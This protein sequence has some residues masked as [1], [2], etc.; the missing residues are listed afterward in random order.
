MALKQQLIIIFKTNKIFIVS[1]SD[2]EELDYEPITITLCDKR[3][4]HKYDYTLNKFVLVRRV[5][6]Y[7]NNP[8]NAETWKYTHNFLV[9]PEWT[10][11]QLMEDI[12]SRPIPRST[13]TAQ[14][15]LTYLSCYNKRLDLHNSATLAALGIGEDATIDI[16]DPD[17]AYAPVTDPREEI[18]RQGLHITADSPPAQIF[19]R[20][21]GMI[22]SRECSRAYNDIIREKIQE[23][24]KQMHDY[25]PDDKMPG[26]NPDQLW[27]Y[28]K[29]RIARIS[30]K[31]DALVF[32]V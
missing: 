2:D 17:G 14:I 7:T 10:A 1:M 12:A 11:H 9:N 29:G 32:L 4:Y 24:D 16:M 31:S 8:H 27:E 28:N 26:R 19:P 13:A 18:K 5:E 15:D 22:W 23:R 20:P 25:D 30:K 6:R 3:S 21:K